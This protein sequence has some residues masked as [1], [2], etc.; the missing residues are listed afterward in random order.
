MKYKYNKYGLFVSLACLWLTACSDDDENMQTTEPTIAKVVSESSNFTT[1]NAALKRAGLDSTLAGQGPFTVFAP[2]DEA[3]QASGITDINALPVDS[4]KQVLLYHVISGAKVPSSQVKTGIVTSAAELSL[5]VNT[6]SG[7]AINGG[8]SI[9]GGGTVTQADVP[10][11]NGVVHIIDRVLLPPDISACAEYG[12]LTE[13]LKAVGAAAPLEDGTKLADAIKTPGPFTV[14][15]PTNEAFGALTSTPPAATL[16]DVLL[17]H[18]HGAKVAS[19]ALPAKAD[20]LLQNEWKHGVTL[21]F[22]KTPEPKVNDAKIAVTDIQCTNGTV[23]VIDKVLL[24]PNV[25]DMAGIAGLT[26]LATAIGNAA[27]LPGNVSVADALK[28]PEPYT[29]FAPTNAAFAAITVPTNTSTLRDVLLLHVLNTGSPVLSTG[30][31]NT[32]VNTLLTNEK[33]SFDAT[34]P[35]VISDGTPAPGAKISVTDVNVTNGVIH[36]IDAVLL[37]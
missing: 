1:L 28:Q 2:T 23:H 17:Y 19:S 3:F 33:V 27:N 11:S 35:S 15:A 9:K 18:V 14:F 5:F 16:R 10:A 7:V 25:V 36:V 30:L 21:L 13:L 37:P 6:S 12:G 26:S 32:A 20:S 24:P 22:S 4:L 8:N 29:V 31:P 34:Q